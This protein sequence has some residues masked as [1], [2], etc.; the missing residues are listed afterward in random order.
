MRVVVLAGPSGSGKSRLAA[1]VGLPRVALDDFYRGADDPGLPRRSLGAGVEI[2]DWD[3]PRSWDGAAAVDALV[4]LCRDREADLPV[5]DIAASR[6]TGWRRLDLRDSPVEIVVAEGI[7]AAEVVRPLREAG[8]LAEAL[9]LAPPRWVV[10][11][12]RLAR[13]LAERRKP[14]GVLVRRGLAL[15]R[16]DPDVV[17]RAVA[18]GCLPV[19]ADGAERRLARL[20]G[21]RTAWAQPD[22]Y[23]CGAAVL[24]RHRMLTDPGFARRIDADPVPRFVAEVELARRRLSGAH[25]PGGWR[26]PW[27]AL[28][29][30]SPWALA[31]ETGRSVRVVRHEVGTTSAL[32]RAALAHGPTPVYVGNRRLPRHVVLALPATDTG[33]RFYDPADGREHIRAAADL[34]EGRADLAGWHT[35]WLLLPPR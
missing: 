7:F 9:C 8:V 21:R 13:D 31:A 18:V 15:T 33:L 4:R 28:L 2:V 35:P 10:F 34:D 20:A 19:T 12:R 16:T 1:R 5:Y 11:A 14:P 3:D 27:P 17:A 6:R 26:V 23:S 29:G 32:L 24:V 30:T 25:G 22:A